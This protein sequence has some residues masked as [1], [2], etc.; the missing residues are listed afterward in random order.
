MSEIRPEVVDFIFDQGRTAADRQLR[1]LDSLDSKATQLFSAATVIVGLAGFSGQANAGILTAAVVVYVLVAVAALYA[2]WLVKIRVTD[3]PR[4]LLLRYW[5]QPVLDTKYAM[6]TDM[7]EGFAEN[8]R[9]LGRKRRGVLC[10]LALT[11]VET[12][13]IGVAVIATLWD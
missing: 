10:A 8:E 13:L 7:A 11:G 4:Q 12:A 6:V 1:D 3:S 2:L 5:T 9:S